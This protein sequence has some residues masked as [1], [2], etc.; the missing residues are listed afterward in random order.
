MVGTS[1]RIGGMIGRSAINDDRTWDRSTSVAAPRRASSMPPMPAELVFPH[2]PER[3]RR[4]LATMADAGHE[5]ALVGGVVRDRLLGLA[6]LGEWDAAT[7]ARPEEVAALFEGA[8]WENRFGT[9]T[10]GADPLVEITSYRAEGAYRDRRRPDEVRFGVS[11]AEDLARR[12]FTINAMGWLPTDLDAGRGTL[13]DPHAGQ[14]DLDA[15]LLRAVGD[16]AE[17]FAEDALRLIR[18]ARFAGRF[19][20]AID[21]GTEAAIGQLAPTVAS[22]SAERVRDELTRI[23]ADDPVPSRAIGLLERLGLLAVVIPELA[24]LRGIPQAKAVPGDALDHS[25]RAVDAAPPTSP[26]VLRIAAL[27]HDVGKARTLRDGHFFGHDR[28]S[29]DMAAAIL[30][31]LRLPRAQLERVVGAVLHHMYDYDST[32]TDAAV[33]RFVRR[34]AGVD[35]ELLF[36]LRRADNLASGVG[37]EGDANQDELEAR[38]AEQI[39]AEPG[40]LVERR[41]AIDG[42]DLQRELGM[43]PGP[44]IGA[45]LDRLTEI[46]LDDPSQNRRDILLA[47][48]RRR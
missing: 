10:I 24:A 30:H 46:V 25:L 20:L 48:A 27:L 38:I 45:V 9:V 17:R 47:H 7:A 2:L 31:R 41:L 42:H 43:E 18:A 44:E 19:Q 8:T 11:L 13:I 39:G 29:A 6:H 28:V 23:L 33:R 37:P 14:A 32:W 4:V 26:P 12:D 15:R 5:V 1:G 22:V 3:V 36:A 16:P 34:L 35:R 21:P 40:L